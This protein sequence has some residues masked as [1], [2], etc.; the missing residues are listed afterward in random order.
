M[1]YM[2]IDSA[3]RQQRREGCTVFIESRGNDLFINV[4]KINYLKIKTV[5]GLSSEILACLDNGDM[6][7][8]ARSKEEEQAQKMLQSIVGD[9]NS[10]WQ[11][12]YVVDGQIDTYPHE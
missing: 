3:G 6:L 8:I 4:D 5:A 1:S 9:I 7:P 12:V 11:K 2:Q 10:H